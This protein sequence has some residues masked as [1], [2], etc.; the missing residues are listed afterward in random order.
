MNYAKLANKIV[1]QSE[2]K[3]KFLKGGGEESVRGYNIPGTNYVR[4]VNSLCNGAVTSEADN[5]ASV[6]D[7]RYHWH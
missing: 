7:W 5:T 3:K 2:T 1:V 6:Q 4:P